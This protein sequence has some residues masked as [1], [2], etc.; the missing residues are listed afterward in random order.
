MLKGEGSTKIV[1]FTL[2]DCIGYFTLRNK[3]IAFA[4][5]QLSN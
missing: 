1:K 2:H 3:K 4:A 5:N